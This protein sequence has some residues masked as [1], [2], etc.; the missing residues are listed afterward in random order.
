MEKKTLPECHFDPLHRLNTNKLLITTQHISSP[1][2]NMPPHND[3][4]R[5]YDFF[6]DQLAR[7]RSGNQILFS[8]NELIIAE[9]GSAVSIRTLRYYLA[10]L[11]IS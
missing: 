6:L 10:K 7:N 1:Y 2:L 5:Y 8:L 3:L 9:G 4:T 11:G